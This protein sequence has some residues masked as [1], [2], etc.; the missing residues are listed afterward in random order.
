RRGGGPRRAGPPAP[1]G[2]VDSGAPSG[3]ADTI[4]TLHSELAPFGASFGCQSASFRLSLT[5]ALLETLRQLSYDVSPDVIAAAA[6]DA[7]SPSNETVSVHL[8]RTRA[9]DGELLE[10]R[11]VTRPYFGLG[12]SVVS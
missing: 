5:P 7:A 11:A 2:T 1:G 9:V 6:R 3:E 10:A 12:G 4:Y 8:V